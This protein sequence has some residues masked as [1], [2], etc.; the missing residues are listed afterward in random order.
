[1]KNTNCLIHNFLTSTYVS[2]IKMK[3]PHPKAKEKPWQ[4]TYLSCPLS[5]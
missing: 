4:L 5:A 2:D 1:M 3:I